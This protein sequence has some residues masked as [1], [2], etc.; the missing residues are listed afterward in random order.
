MVIAPP[1]W[2][3]LPVSPSGVNERGCAGN[4]LVR[5]DAAGERVEGKSDWL[6]PASSFSQLFVCFL[7]VCPTPVPL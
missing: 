3:S 6:S 5:G 1:N 7:L 2:P 4:T